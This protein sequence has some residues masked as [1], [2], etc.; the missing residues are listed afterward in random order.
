ME[1]DILKLLK[2]ELG[3]PTIKT[4]LR[5]PHWPTSS[6]CYCLISTWTCWLM[7][8]LLPHVFRF[9]DFRRFTRSAHEDKKV[10]NPFWFII[11]NCFLLSIQCALMSDVFLCILV[12][13]L[14]LVNG[15]LGELPR[16]VEPTRLWLSPVLAICS[17]C[18]SF[19]CC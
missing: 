10:A 2:F 7:E 14:H 19:V 3:N 17:C 9:A 6:Y 4:F 13:A 8:Y 1:S 18:F 16:W 11:S 15:I 5:C 12:A